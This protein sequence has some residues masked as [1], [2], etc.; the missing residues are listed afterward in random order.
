[1][2]ANLSE[3]QRPSFQA[4]KYAL[5]LWAGKSAFWTRQLYGRRQRYDGK[6]VGPQTD[7][8][9]EGFPRSGNTY[10]VAA[11]QLAQ[12]MEVRIASHLH[13]PSQITCGMQLNIPVLV[14]IREPI[15]ALTSY[16]IREP[17]VSVG[18]MVT[19]YRRF[20]DCALSSRRSV[21]LCTFEQLTA[22][23]DA[24]IQRANARFGTRWKT[25]EDS[26]VS[27]DDIF[28]LVEEMERSDSDGA[29]I[30]ETHV[31]RPSSSR[32]G[33]KDAARTALL[34]QVAPQDLA[35]CNS[36]FDE[37]SAIAQT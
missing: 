22:D 23:F 25:T 20:Y 27:E 30:R 29:T 12:D 2:P 10:F 34:A 26:N 5:R 13:Y 3:V 16:Y 18:H 7:V 4:A 35:R 8:V 6:V 37:I 28:Q 1:M 9:I 32:K 11:F 36:L 19:H 24:I 15:E 33:E 31:A 21:L 14:V 17:S